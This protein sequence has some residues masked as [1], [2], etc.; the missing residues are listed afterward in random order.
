MTPRQ[1]AAYVVLAGNRRKQLAA[2]DLVLNTYAAQ[3]S[4]KDI[5]AQLKSLLK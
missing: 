4:N 2:E 3:G 1:I 5:N